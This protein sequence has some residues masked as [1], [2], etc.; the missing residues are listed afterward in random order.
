MTKPLWAC[1]DLIKKKQLLLELQFCPEGYK[2]TVGFVIEPG[3]ISILFLKHVTAADIKIS[4]NQ[5]DQPQI[6]T[7]HLGIG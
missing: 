6:G 2:Q 7:N 4:V 5:V 1:G 3:N